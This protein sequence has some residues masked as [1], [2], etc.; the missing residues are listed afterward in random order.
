MQVVSVQKKRIRQKQKKV[1]IKSN[2]TKEQQKA[3]IGDALRSSRVK[4]LDKMTK[5]KG[6]QNIVTEIAEDVNV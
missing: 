6:E 2:L 4:E 1:E 5:E 3:V